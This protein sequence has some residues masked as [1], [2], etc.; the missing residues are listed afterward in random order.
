MLTATYPNN[1]IKGTTKLPRK[2]IS[3]KQAV[4]RFLNRADSQFK[5]GA[6]QDYEFAMIGLREYINTFGEVMLRTAGIAPTIG[7]RS[8]QDD[9]VWD[10]YEPVQIAHL[11]PGFRYFFLPHKVNAS[12][13]VKKLWLMIIREFLDWLVKRRYLSSD[14]ILEFEVYHSGLILRAAQAEQILRN[15]ILHRGRGRDKVEDVRSGEPLYVVSRVKSGRAW[16]I[17]CDSTINGG[18]K[19]DEFGPVSIPC[20]ASDLIGPGWCIETTFDK[21]GGRWQ[22]CTVGTVLAIGV[23]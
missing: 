1:D 21:R 15:W 9:L 20:G 5:L 16:F 17:Y 12:E 11:L 6:Y 13:E 4:D 19:Y 10:V 8:G 23:E 14:A 3:V 22:M 7:Q 18:T 2:A